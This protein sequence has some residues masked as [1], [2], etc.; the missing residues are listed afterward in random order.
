MFTPGQYRR[1]KTLDA[2]PPTVRPWFEALMLH[3][4]Q[5]GYQPAIV[6]AL[7]TCREEHGLAL[8][9]TRRSWHVLGRAVDIELHAR[10]RQPSIAAAYNELGEWWERQGG[11]WGGRWIELYPQAPGVP[12]MS[13][14]PMHFHW[15]D[16]KDSVPRELWPEG[17]TCDEIDALQRRYLVAHG[18]L[19]VE[20]FE[21]AASSPATPAAPFPSSSSSSSVAKRSNAP[22]WIAF[23]LVVF[24]AAV[25]VHRS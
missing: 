25:R 19:T 7:R 1:L 20:A 16:G 18:G 21:A 13:G 15:A 11:N 14:D 3:A 5:Q 17:A 2:L 23:G 10:G 24:A 4:T 22:A 8:T 6:S 12:G 9:K